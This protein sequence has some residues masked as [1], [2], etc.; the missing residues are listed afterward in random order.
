MFAFGYCKKEFKDIRRGII[1][2]KLK[3]DWQHNGLKKK[4][5]TTKGQTTIYKTLHIKPKIEQ[6][7]SNQKLG[8][9]PGAPEG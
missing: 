4:D 8:A 5:K 9:N 6:R 2:C 3:M 1:I 7:K